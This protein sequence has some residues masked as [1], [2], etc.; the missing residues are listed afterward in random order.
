MFSIVAE[1]RDVA[2]SRDTFVFN[3]FIDGR[4]ASMIKSMKEL[5][6]LIKKRKLIRSDISFKD[7]QFIISQPAL[8]I[9]YDSCVNTDK[10]SRPLEEFFD[11]SERVRIEIHRIPA[12]HRASWT[13]HEV[14]SLR[15][16]AEKIRSDIERM[17]TAL[18]RAR[19]F[20]RET[21]REIESATSTGK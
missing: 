17:E 18:R 21:E 13:S 5:F 14:V 6:R 12:E 15:R 3:H 11:S 9:T 2:V 16:K 19:E 1:F 7:A 20:L 8:G 10:M 4:E